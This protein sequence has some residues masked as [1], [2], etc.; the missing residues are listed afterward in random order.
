VAR[1]RR[2]GAVGVRLRAAG[3]G[4][5]FR[6]RCVQLHAAA[7]AR[8]SARGSLRGGLP[9]DRQYGFGCVWG[10]RGWERRR[11]EQRCC[12]AWEGGF[13]FCQRAAVG[14]RDVGAE[15]MVLGLVG[16]RGPGLA[17]AGDS[18]SF[19]SPKE[20]KQ[21]KGDPTGC[22]PSLRYG[23]PAVLTFRGVSSKLAS[24]KQGRA[25]IRETLR[26]SAHPEGVGDQQAFAA[27]G[28]RTA[29]IHQPR[30]ESNEVPTAAGAKRLQRPGGRAKR[31]PDRFPSPSGCAE[32]RSVS[33]IRARSCL[34]EASSARPR[35]TR[36]PQVARSEAQGRRQW[37]RLSLLTFFGEAKKVSRL[38]GRVPASE[39]KP[40]KKQA[41][42]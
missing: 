11:R 31:W 21:R 12:V 33:R 8:V 10:E 26:S 36:A 38:P 28:L 25:L 39:N 23:Q 19:A 14:Y 35:E 16:G 41:A 37:G 13:G 29:N 22:V 18:L 40:P 5:V 34:S 42:C 1:A 4:R 3:A 24:L 17:P 9:G 32:E 20:S 27:L 2:C 30:A 7:A 6:G 15:L